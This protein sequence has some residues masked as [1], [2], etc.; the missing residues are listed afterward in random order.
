MSVGYE[1]GSGERRGRPSPSSLW[2]DC[3]TVGF[4]RTPMDTVG[5]T[6]AGGGRAFVRPSLLVHQPPALISIIDVHVSCVDTALECYGPIGAWVRSVGSS[7]YRSVA[8][9]VGR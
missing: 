2:D 6:L 3:G 7:V 9:Y 8:R 5:R 1:E 4:I